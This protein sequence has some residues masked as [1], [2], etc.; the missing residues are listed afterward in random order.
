MLPWL[1]ALSLLIVVVEAEAICS[2]IV[3]HPGDDPAYSYAVSFVEALSHGKQATQRLSAATPGHSGLEAATQTLTV[4]ERVAKDFECAANLMAA[5]ENYAIGHSPE[6]AVKVQTVAR[7]S[8]ELA[9]LAYLALAEGT[10][11]S[12]ELIDQLLVGQ[13]QMNQTPGRWRRSRHGW[14][15][16]GT[17]FSPSRLLSLTSSSILSPMRPVVSVGCGSLRPSAGT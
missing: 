2:P 10:R 4:L 15:T 7:Q 16:S 5:E 17:P 11:S 3:R 14:T 8:A 13:V 9:K 1:A 12:A 6:I